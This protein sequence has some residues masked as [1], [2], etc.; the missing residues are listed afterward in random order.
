MDQAKIVLIASVI[1]VSRSG[2]Y[3]HKRE[4]VTLSVDGAEPLYCE[5]R[6]PN[7]HGWAMGQQMVV[8]IA[9]MGKDA[10]VTTAVA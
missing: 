3:F 6:L 2:I 10:V 7:K 5:L 4:R 1:E 9:P 8:T